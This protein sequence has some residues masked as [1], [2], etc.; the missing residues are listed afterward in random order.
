MTEELENLSREMNYE[1]KLVY[2]L[3]KD[4]LGQVFYSQATQ[5]VFAARML[6]K[7]MKGFYLEIGGGHPQ[8]SNNTYMLESQYQWDGLSLEYNED[9][10]KLYNLSRRNQTICADATTFDYQTKLES[11][12]APFQIDYLS[13]DIDPARYTYLALNG[14]PHENYRFSVIT[15]EHDRYQSGE[16]FMVSSRSLLRSL[17]Y[18]L[19]V[20]NVMTFGKDFEDWWIDP[21]VIPK[22]IWK[23]MQNSMIDFADLW[24]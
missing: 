13:L 5:D 22:A 14:L 4:N 19:V 7:K 11:M 24:N 1:K 10:A 2:S 9:L 16:E 6:E 15:Y 23:P 3:L 8:D 18:E 12:N 21:R 20:S 17:G